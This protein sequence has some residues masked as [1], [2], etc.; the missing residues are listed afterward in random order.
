[1]RRFNYR[2][3][4]RRLP[5]LARMPLSKRAERYLREHFAHAAK[6][7]RQKAKAKSRRD[8]VRTYTITTMGTSRGVS[9]PHLRMSGRWLERCGFGA[10]ARV[11]VT[12]E[13]G[14]LV[15]TAADPALATA[16]QEN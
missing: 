14:R 12:V 7:T 11:F 10:R 9:V 5:A 1:M 3:L 15:L 16:V 6:E 13:P 2:E 8:G 4:R